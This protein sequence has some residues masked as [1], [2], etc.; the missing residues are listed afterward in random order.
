M[1]I[2]TWSDEFS[3]HVK[4]IDAQHR[5]LFKLVNDLHDAMLKGQ[6]KTVL[7]TILDELVDYTRVHF[8]T[9]EEL[10]QHCNYVGLAGHRIEHDQFTKKVLDL[11]TRCGKGEIGLTIQVM[12]F[13]K[14]WLKNH[15]TGTDKKYSTALH[16]RGVS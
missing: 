13:L 14:D 2:I 12:D 10:M 6:G 8:T 16:A 1:P 15:I 9:E 4:E 11:K 5:H 3:V 7:A